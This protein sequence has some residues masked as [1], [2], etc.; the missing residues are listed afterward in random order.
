MNVFFI[1]QQKCN[2]NNTVDDDNYGYI[3]RNKD[4]S[5]KNTSGKFYFLSNHNISRGVEDENFL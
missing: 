1:L 2:Q 4:Y 3:D 5:V